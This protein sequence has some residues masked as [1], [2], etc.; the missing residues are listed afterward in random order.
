MPPVATE[1]LP[2]SLLECFERG[3]A[4]A[5]L[6]RLLRFLSPLTLAVGHIWTLL[7]RRRV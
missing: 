2:A 5:Q 4:Q 1:R 6:T 3:A 7:S